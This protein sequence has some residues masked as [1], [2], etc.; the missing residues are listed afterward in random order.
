M[1]TGDRA[2]TWALHVTGNWRIT[3]RIDS[4]EIEIIDLTYEDYH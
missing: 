4:D 1:M 2:G 3:F